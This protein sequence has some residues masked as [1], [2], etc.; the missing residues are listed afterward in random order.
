VH[1]LGQLFERGD[2][3]VDFRERRHLRGS[4]HGA[5]GAVDGDHELLRLGPLD[6]LRQM[7]GGHGNPLG[8]CWYAGGLKKSVA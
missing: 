3:G 2:A 5:L 6:W 7:L 4:C 1:R 8:Y